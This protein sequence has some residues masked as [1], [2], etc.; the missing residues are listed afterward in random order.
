[1]ANLATVYATD[2]DAFVWA[3]YDFLTICPRHQLLAQATDGAFTAG[4]FTLT[5]VSAGFVVAGVKTGMVCQLTDPKSTLPGNV[6]DFLE[7]DSLTATTLV[8]KRVH[9]ATGQ[10]KPP[11]SA[12][13]AN[14]SYKIATLYPQIEEASYDLNERFGLNREGRGPSELDDLRQLRRACLSI[15]LRDA[16]SQA[17]RMLGQPTDDFSAKADRYDRMASDMLAKLSLRWAPE[18]SSYPPTNVFSTRISR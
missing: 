18:N 5:S 13:T 11:Y 15:V 6:A 1:M 14:V 16:Y 7:V 4:G 12:I 3:G 17:A 2:A 8:L 10:G 9:M